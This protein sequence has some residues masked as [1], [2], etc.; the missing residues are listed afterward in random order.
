MECTHTCTYI[1]VMSVLVAEQQDGL[2]KLSIWYSQVVVVHVK[3]NMEAHSCCQAKDTE[4][5]D[6][7]R[8]KYLTI[9]NCF[10]R[11]KLCVLKLETSPMF[12]CLLSVIWLSVYLSVGL[13]VCL[14]LCLSVCLSV[15]LFHCLSVCSTDRE[16]NQWCY[17]NFVS[18]RSMK[19]ADNVREQLSRI[20]DR[21]ALRRTSTEFTSRDYYINIRKALLSGFFMQVGRAVGM[22]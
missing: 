16:E 11:V 13:S 4:D 19:S 22:V 1:A 6:I 8:Q 14:S 9:L 17:D 3:V 10:M 18:N 21:L 15:C 7:M 12:V 5:V 20:M 2:G